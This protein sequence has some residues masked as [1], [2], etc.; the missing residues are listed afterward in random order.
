MEKYKHVGPIF[1]FRIYIS[2]SYGKIVGPI[3]NGSNFYKWVLW[4]NI[5][6]WVPFSIAVFL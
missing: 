2:E 1:N 5:N 3:C 6:K 4:E